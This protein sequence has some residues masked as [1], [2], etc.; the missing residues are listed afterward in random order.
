M[1]KLFNML[2]KTSKHNKLFYFVSPLP[3]DYNDNIKIA[4]HWKQGYMGEMSFWGI[5]RKEGNN[6]QWRTHSHSDCSHVYGNDGKHSTAKCLFIV[7]I[8]TE[9]KPVRG[10]VSLA[11]LVSWI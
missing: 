3:K 8:L 7:Y 2:E 10:E 9:E 5:N 11:T 6:A 1:R 4:A